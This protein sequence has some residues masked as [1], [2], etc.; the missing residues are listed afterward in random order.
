MAQEVM[1]NQ[2]SRTKDVF[3]IHLFGKRE[4]EPP[5]DFVLLNPRP[6]MGD[7]RPE[8]DPA[9]TGPRL[10]SRYSPDCVLSLEKSPVETL[11]PV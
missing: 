5:N 1:W 6:L 8:P 9:T 2:W 4:A 10:L 7:A 11:L 3:V